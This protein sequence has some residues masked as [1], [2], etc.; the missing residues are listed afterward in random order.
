MF[1]GFLVF[2][3]FGSFFLFGM[4][5]GKDRSKKE[6]YSHDKE[7]YLFPFVRKFSFVCLWETILQF[8]RLC[9]VRGHSF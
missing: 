3:F 6:N 1:F 8:R 9:E 2:W 7:D 5:D 4:E